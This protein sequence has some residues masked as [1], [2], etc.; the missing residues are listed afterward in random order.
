M[1]HR[2]R[3]ANKEVSKGVAQIALGRGKRIGDMSGLGGGIRMGTGG[4]QLWEG[5]R[6]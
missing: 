5:W 2:P 4:L 6:N 1:T 3:E